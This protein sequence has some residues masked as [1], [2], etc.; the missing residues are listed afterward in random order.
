MP[1]RQI[2]IRRECPRKLFYEK[3]LHD[4]KESTEDRNQRTTIFKAQQSLRI[5]PIEIN[6]FAELKNMKGIGNNIATKLD[7][8]WQLM[9]SQYQA[10]PTLTQIK[11]LKKGEFIQFMGS[12]AG[13]RSRAVPI[14]VAPSKE[15]M[16][17]VHSVNFSVP[18][19]SGTGN[20]IAQTSTST[21]QR[22]TSLPSAPVNA[23]GF[24]RQPSASSHSSD[25]RYSPA[26]RDQVEVCLIV[27]NREKSGLLKK[28]DVSTF[29]DKLGTRY[30][31]RSL[32]VGDYLWVLKWK[33]SGAEMVLDYI[34]ERKTWQDLWSSIK[35]GRFDDQK[36]RLKNCEV[37]NIVLIVEGAVSPER[38]MEQALASSSIRNSFMV[39]RTA[40]IQDTAKFLH[41]VSNR[42][43]NR[44]QTEHMKGIAFDKL[45]NEGKKTKSMTVSDVWARQLTV[46]P[47]MGGDKAAQV[48]EEFPSFRAMAEFCRHAKRSDPYFNF[49]DHLGQKNPSLNRTVRSTLCEFFSNA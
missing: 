32:S 6:G 10:I 2:T 11:E 34:C 24:S 33:H 31:L 44:I 15:T 29:L 43:I 37:D 18:S 25:I 4:W 21:L 41:A 42:L 8:A 46:C 17:R 19:T 5:Y 22:S 28:R 30:E 38:A 23:I 36:Q 47:Q 7:D 35:K 48:A 12:A 13:K 49:A 26:E 27:D 3:L 14:S 45:Q 9:C 39:Q 40:S 16:P 20:T 1:K